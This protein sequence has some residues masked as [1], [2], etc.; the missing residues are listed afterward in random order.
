[1][2]RAPALE[3]FA[4]MRCGHLAPRSSDGVAA[5]G[6]CGVDPCRSLCTFLF[7]E[8]EVFTNGHTVRP[9][10]MSYTEVNA[11]FPAQPVALDCGRAHHAALLG[12]DSALGRLHVSTQR[13]LIRVA[14]SRSRP[15]HDRQVHAVKDASPSPRYVALSAYP[16]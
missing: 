10:Y 6:Q 2:C 14:T 13:S 8:H 4:G 1:M 11:A 9:D 3:A 5:R 7:R 16:A 15:C 12:A